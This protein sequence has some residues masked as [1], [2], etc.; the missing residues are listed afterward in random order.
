MPNANGGWW[1]YCGGGLLEFVVK[2]EWVWGYGEDMCW[3]VY[4]RY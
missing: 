4:V 1:C 3:W 2:V